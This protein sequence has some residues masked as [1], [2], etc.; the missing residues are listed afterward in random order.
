MHKL[1]EVKTASWGHWEGI[2]GVLE[3]FVRRSKDS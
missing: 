1:D 3:T 2:V